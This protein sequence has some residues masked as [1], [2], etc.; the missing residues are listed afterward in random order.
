MSSPFDY[1]AITFKS[2]DGRPHPL[3]IPGMMTPQGAAA[4]PQP[5]RTVVANVRM[6]PGNKTKPVTLM[7]MGSLYDWHLHLSG[8]GDPPTDP[9]MLEH[10]NKCKGRAHKNARPGR[11]IV[12][13]WARYVAR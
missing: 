13:Q 3:N 8:P 2:P 1:A 9:A 11:E 7:F 12:T 10:L 4:L 5:V 6:L